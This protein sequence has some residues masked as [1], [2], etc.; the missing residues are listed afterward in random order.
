MSYTFQGVIFN[1]SVN[2][3]KRLVCSVSDDRSIRLYCWSYPSEETEISW[4]AAVF[5]LMS[6]FNGHTSRV[7][8]ARILDDGLISIG[9]DAL[10]ITWNMDGSMR[11][12]VKIHKVLSSLLIPCR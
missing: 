2:Y 7:W 6:V 9:E 5:K 11:R 10:L 12:Q 4:E 3:P 1:M 8:D